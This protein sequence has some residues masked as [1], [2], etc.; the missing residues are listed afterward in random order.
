MGRMA[1]HRSSYELKVGPIPNGLMV[2]HDCDV[3][4][5]FNPEHLYVG[6]HTDNAVDMVRRGRANRAKG[7][8]HASCKLTLEEV[9]RIRE[10][11]R[12]P[13]RKYGE[14]SAFARELGI[15]KGNISNIATGKTWRHLAAAQSKRGAV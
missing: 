7:T 13:E 3:P 14:M 8:R 12:N 11:H 15:S 5:C 1:V 2:L 9:C 6:T 10:L 4:A